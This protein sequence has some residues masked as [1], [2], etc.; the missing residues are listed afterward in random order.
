MVI[1]WSM[2]SL[3]GNHA[4]QSIPPV[5]ADQSVAAISFLFVCLV[6]SF[7]LSAVVWSTRRYYGFTKVMSLILYL[8]VVQFFLT[9][10]E[11]YF[12]SESI[13][14]SNGQILSI[15]IAGLV[16]S[17]ITVPLAILIGNK[18]NR[19]D[20]R[21]VFKL[22]WPK[23]PGILLP[24]VLLIFIVYPF[25]YFT[26]GYFIAWQN[27]N[28]RIFYTHSDEIKPFFIQTSEGFLNGVY[29]FQ[30]LRGM[31]W[32]TFSVPVILML[33]QNKISQYLLVGFL[34]ALLPT[35]QLFIPNPYM[36]ADIALTHF[37][38]TSV[39]NFLW[40]IVMTFT[41][42]KYF[43]SGILQTKMHFN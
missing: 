38:E 14:I 35:T 1:T 11:T 27:E 7:L 40:G 19:V 9:Q 42:N 43:H 41:I 24:L 21:T 13:Q 33:Q 22:G 28:L 25:L 4:T 31:I 17:L 10:M 23:S 6:N 37:V 18:V 2:G 36:P 3:I 30:L 26:F 39:S 15:V 29:L 5:A 32:I 12:F 16:M 8:F 20:S 34:S